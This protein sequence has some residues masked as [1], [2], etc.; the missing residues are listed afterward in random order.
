MRL[1]EPLPAATPFEGVLAHRDA[2]LQ[3]YRAF[4]RT[5][6]NETR[7]PVRT[8][9]LCRLRVAAIH[10]CAAELA[11]S[12]A[13][14]VLAPAE[15]AAVLAGDAGA[16]VACFT[17]AEQAALALAEAMPYRHHHIED[18]EVA[19]ARSLL[20]NEGAVALLTAIAFFDVNCRLK[21]V[22]EVPAA[23]LADVA[24][25]AMA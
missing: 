21:L 12:T 6:W 20:G 10:D 23:P 8:L 4:Q 17:A 15:R 2:L 18:A 19:R 9:E 11:V 16:C 13:G 24:P 5:L 7:V 3:R 1:I 22:L 25:G 14:V